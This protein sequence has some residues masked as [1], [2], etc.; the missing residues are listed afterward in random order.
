MQRYSFAT[1]A[2]TR[3]LPLRSPSKPSSFALINNAQAL[4]TNPSNAKTSA[5][6]YNIQSLRLVSSNSG[7]NKS[8]G[9]T[10]A[11]VFGSVAVLSLFGGTL[12][13]AGIDPEFRAY[14]EG[15][16]PGAKEAFDTIIGNVG[17][18]EW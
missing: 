18:D 5:T 12:G 2:F 9:G 4:K 13:Y 14:V 17:Q 7:S 10:K 3:C 11:A 6:S 15:V 8:G 1:K 16:I